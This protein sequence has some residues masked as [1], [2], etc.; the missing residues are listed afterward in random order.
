MNTLTSWILS[1]RRMMIGSR[2][3]N[4]LLKNWAPVFS[5]FRTVSKPSWS[6][7][8]LQSSQKRNFKNAKTSRA[9]RHSLTPLTTQFVKPELTPTRSIHSLRC[10][11]ILKTY[12]KRTSASF[13]TTRISHS[14]RAD[15]LKICKTNSQTFSSATSRAILESRIGS[16]KTS[17]RASSFRSKVPSSCTA[18]RFWTTFRNVFCCRTYSQYLN[19]RAALCHLMGSATRS[20]DT[21]RL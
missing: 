21:C 17:Y 7:S 6:T 18:S 2:M 14:R 16:I 15:L 11:M 19:G 9:K 3:S 13:P 4:S 12:W 8:F 5:Q 1:C 20:V 10:L